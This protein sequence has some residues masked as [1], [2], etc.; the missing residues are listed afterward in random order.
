M[1]LMTYFIIPR[2]LFSEGQ[3][4]QCPWEFTE[5]IGEVLA[6]NYVGQNYIFYSNIQTPL[7][8]SKIRM[9]GDSNKCNEISLDI[10]KT[11]VDW[12]KSTFEKELLMLD[13]NLPLDTDFKIDVKIGWVYLPED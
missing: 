6:F 13:K 1:E 7:D 3:A 2:K 10:L 8:K 5:Q 11:D 4:F 12:F 9:R